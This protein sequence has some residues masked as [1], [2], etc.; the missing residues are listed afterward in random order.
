[1]PINVPALVS[2]AHRQ[3][4]NSTSKVSSGHTDIL[5]SERL[6]QSGLR[7]VTGRGC[8]RTAIWWPYSCEVS[9]L[10]LHISASYE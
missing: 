7:V 8:E 1:M 5:E 4:A 10:A 3:T 9:L 6:R 2:P